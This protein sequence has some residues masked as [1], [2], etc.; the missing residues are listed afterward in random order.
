[1][2]GW[3]DQ[4]AGVEGIKINTGDLFQTLMRRDDSGDTG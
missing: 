3:A 4:A 1:V 2:L